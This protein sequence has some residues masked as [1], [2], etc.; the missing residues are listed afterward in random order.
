MVVPLQRMSLFVPGDTAYLVPIE[1][2][3]CRLYSFLLFQ[4]FC[5]NLPLQ[6]H[7]EN[8]GVS[9]VW[10]MPSTLGPVPACLVRK[11]SV[12]VVGDTSGAT[13]T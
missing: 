13:R 1:L 2:N 3:P 9:P 6:L 4:I 5:V 7:F 11:L 8:F 10:Y 12:A